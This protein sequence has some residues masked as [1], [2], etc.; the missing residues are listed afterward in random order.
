MAAVQ[1][2]RL[3]GVKAHLVGQRVHRGIGNI[4]V[5]ICRHGT[6]GLLAVTGRINLRS[7]TD[8]RITAALAALG[9]LRGRRGRDVRGRG[10]LLGQGL[11][12]RQSRRRSSSQHQHSRQQRH[13]PHPLPHTLTFLFFP[14]QMGI[15]IRKFLYSTRKDK[16]LPVSNNI[17][18]K[19]FAEKIHKEQSR[20]GRHRSGDRI[21]PLRAGC[22]PDIWSCRH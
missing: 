7:G 5:R 1:R 4:D 13:Q 11:Q 21:T 16:I 3:R 19:F 8:H 10:D 20:P 18:Q 15:A 9:G 17:F 14:I 12:G 2:R 6:D 22:G